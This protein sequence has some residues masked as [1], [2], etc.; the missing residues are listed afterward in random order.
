MMA[1]KLTHFVAGDTPQPEKERHCG[2]LNVRRQIPPRFQV[3]LLQDIGG[4]DAASEPIVETEHHRAAQPISA[5]L[6][7]RFPAIRFAK[8]GTP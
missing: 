1:M 4:V 5:P 3:R 7:E 6:H 2:L 8:C